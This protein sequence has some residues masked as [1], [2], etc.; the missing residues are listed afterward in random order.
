M[1]EDGDFWDG[2]AME[3]DSLQDKMIAHR[4]SKDKR[5]LLNLQ[6]SI[7]YGVVELLLSIGKARLT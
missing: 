7:N 5:E 4:K 3:E 1:G 2:L 6:S